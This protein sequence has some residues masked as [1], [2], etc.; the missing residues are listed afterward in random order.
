VDMDMSP[1]SAQAEPKERS[2][3]AVVSPQSA[4]AGPEQMN[5]ATVMSPP[6][7]QA[8]LKK[9]AAEIEAAQT[10]IATSA[11]QQTT[12]VGSSSS[13]CPKGAGHPCC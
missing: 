1:L 11:V 8:I 12:Q 5:I 3:A 10:D 13:F 6:S 9:A 4:Q 7:A 2:P